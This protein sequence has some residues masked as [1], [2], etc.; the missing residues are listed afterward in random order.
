M[1]SCFKHS[2]ACIVCTTTISQK[3]KSLKE[4]IKKKKKKSYQSINYCIILFE[5]NIWMHVEMVSLER[6]RCT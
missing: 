6:R 2:V 3:F 1:K 4:G 5:N